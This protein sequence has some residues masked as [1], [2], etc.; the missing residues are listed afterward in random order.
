MSGACAGALGDRGDVRRHRVYFGWYI[1]AAAFATYFVMGATLQGYV[2]GV[3]LVP[4]S[5]DLDW[6]RTEFI[7]A[8]TLAQFV[9]A[10][11][12]ALIGGVIDRHGGR[13]LMFGGIV[14]T[15]FGLLLTAQVTEL[16]Q[17]FALRGVMQGIGIGMAGPLVVSVTLSKWFVRRRGRAIG[18]AAAG[19][20]LG[21]LF[22]PNVITPI[23]DAFG[24]RA[25]WRFLAVVTA[26][27]MVPA[28]LAVRRQPEDYGYQPDGRMEAEETHG[29]RAM[30]AP[31]RLRSEGLTRGQALRTSSFW[32]VVLAFGLGGMGLLVLASQAIPYLTDSGFDRTTA[33]ALVSLLPLPGLLTRAGWG[34]LS[35]KVRPQLLA[36]YAFGGRGR[37][38]ACRGIGRSPQ[39]RL[40]HWSGVSVVRS[41]ELGV[42]HAAGGHVG[43]ALRPSAPGRGPQRGDAVSGRSQR[44]RTDGLLCVL[45][46]RWELRGS[47]RVAGAPVPHSGGTHLEGRRGVG[48]AARPKGGQCR[49]CTLVTRVAEGWQRRTGIGV[50]PRRLPGGPRPPSCLV[51]GALATGPG[52]PRIRDRRSATTCTAPGFLDTSL[53]VI[54]RPPRCAAR[55]PRGRRLGCGGRAV[56]R[57]SAGCSAA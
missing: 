54:M 7:T 32:A 10:A 26:L 36:A 55:A 6:S 31:V 45:R 53:A 49:R 30:S 35:E 20:S 38:D 51:R 15:V 12:G 29:A 28:A 40:G 22:A 5:D 17:W 52:R 18:I 23:V 57:A 11:T 3:F 14:L 34:L 47:V 37:R 8:F 48:D 41:S 9:M 2:T 43:D 42:R 24:W 56:R 4:M 25:G 44:G 50:P 13:R 21:G 1:V 27:V 33:A 16:W 46:H 19:F 39:Q